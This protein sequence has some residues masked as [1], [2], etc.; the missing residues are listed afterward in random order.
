ML[1]RKPKSNLPMKKIAVNGRQIWNL[2]NAVWN[3][4]A[5]VRGATSLSVMS[6]VHAVQTAKYVLVNKGLVKYQALKSS[7]AFSI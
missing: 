5:K 3:V 4:Y 2:R 1:K 6:S 7:T